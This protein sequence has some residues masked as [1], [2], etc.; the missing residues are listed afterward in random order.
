MKKA[1]FIIPAISLLLPG[2]A[3]AT[4]NDLKG[5]ISLIAGYLNDALALLMGIAVVMFVFYV[6]RYF[7]QPSGVER[8]EAAKYLMWSLIGFFIIVSFW[9]IVHILMATFDFGQNSP[10]TWAN[11]FNIIPQS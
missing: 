10:S 2:V 5:V 11:F 4:T 1:R 8:A 3:M 9:G 6:V 7:I